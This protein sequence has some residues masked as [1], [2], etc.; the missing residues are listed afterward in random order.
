MR[1]SKAGPIVSNS[2]LQKRIYE[3]KKQIQQ[4]EAIFDKLPSSIEVW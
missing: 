3:Q 4:L 2:A 1:A